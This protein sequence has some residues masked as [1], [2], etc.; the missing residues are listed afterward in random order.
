MR[1]IVTVI[2]V[3][4]LLGL[5]FLF[6]MSAKGGKISEYFKNAVRVYLYLDKP[7]ARLAA[8]TAAKITAKL[9][10]DELI[11]YLKE[12][13]TVFELLFNTTQEADDFIKK[14]EGLAQEI[15]A[16]N[17]TVQDVMGAKNELGE[18]NPQY[19]QALER[20][21][22]QVFVKEYPALFQTNMVYELVEVAKKE[23]LREVEQEIK[24]MEALK[25]SEIFPPFADMIKRKRRPR[26]TRT[27]MTVT[28]KLILDHW[29]FHE[30]WRHGFP[31]SL[32][33][34]PTPLGLIVKL[35]D[36][37]GQSLTPSPWAKSPAS[38]S[39][40][41]APWPNPSTTA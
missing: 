27:T 12:Q 8:V 13:L 32:Y 16:K 20:S 22:P 24:V 39:R 38:P 19:L 17:W 28:V 23:T 5:L 6:I 40:L 2:V 36:R 35:H 11:A 21:D 34:N 14:L 1:F 15:T 29:G 26:R 30:E 37:T 18:V 4:V 3:L 41:T 9:Q 33:D 7:P 25:Y 31:Q 10:R